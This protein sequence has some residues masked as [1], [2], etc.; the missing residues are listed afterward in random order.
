MNTLSKDIA[1]I[2][3]SY[4]TPQDVYACQQTCTTLYHLFAPKEIWTKFLEK[5][6]PFLNS[7]VRMISKYDATL[8]KQV[9]LAFFG[10]KG[11]PPHLDFFQKVML[12]T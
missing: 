2:I 10:H 8:V 5:K 1:G 11:I 9:A 7:Q 12:K 4:L 6:F 3:A